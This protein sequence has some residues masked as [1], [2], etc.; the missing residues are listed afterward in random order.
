MG[1]WPIVLNALKNSDLVLLVV[2]ARMPEISRNKEILKKT[3]NLKKRT[4][5]VFN[6]IDLISKDDLEKL[7]KENI[8]SHFVSCNKRIGIRELREFLENKAENFNKKSFRIGIVGYP[9]V[10][11]SSIINLIAPKSKLKV[12]KISGTTKKISW[13][14]VGKLRIMDSPGVIPFTDQKTE[15]GLTA[16]KDPYKI[17]DPEKVALKI[18][19]FLNK[20]NKEILKKFYQVNSNKDYDLFLEIGRKKGFLIKGGEID[21][22]RTSRLILKDW[23]TGKIKIF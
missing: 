11:K 4:I 21:I 20:K 8:D 5:I 1:Y 6:K 9:N 3:E 13:I 15:M 23:Q 19:E 14:R 16:S 2:D 10:G 7:K 17:K 22:D 18:V 12:S